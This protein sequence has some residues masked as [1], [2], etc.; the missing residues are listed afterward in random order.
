MTAGRPLPSGSSVTISRT[1]PKSSPRTAARDRRRQGRAGRARSRRGGQLAWVPPARTP[2]TAPGLDAR[3]EWPDRVVGTMGQRPEAGADE[4]RRREN[5][6]A[7]ERRHDV[8]FDDA[9]L[10]VLGQLDPVSEGEPIAY[11]T[12]LPSRS[13]RVS[14]SRRTSPRQAPARRRPSTASWYALGTIARNRTSGVNN[15]SSRSKSP[16]TMASTNEPAE[17]CGRRGRRAMADQSR[18][19]G[20]CEVEHGPGSCVRSDGTT[21][22]RPGHASHRRTT[23]FS[24]RCRPARGGSE[25]LTTR[26][27]PSDHGDSSAPACKAP[28]GADGPS[29]L[30]C[31]A[32]GPQ[33]RPSPSRCR[34][35]GP[36]LGAGW[37]AAE[38]WPRSCGRPVVRA[39]GRHRVHR[40]GRQRHDRRTGHCRLHPPRLPPPSTQKL[41]PLPPTGP[42]LLTLSLRNDPPQQTARLPSSGPPHPPPHLESRHTPPPPP[43]LHPPSAACTPPVR[44]P[45]PPLPPAPPPCPLSHSPS[46]PPPPSLPPPL[47]PYLLAPQRSAYSAKSSAVIGGLPSLTRC[48]RPRMASDR[49]MAR[50]TR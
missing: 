10:A 15:V 21:V 9:P 25:W 30:Q 47:P 35:A 26:P 34:R 46:S 42:S 41:P 7:I 8:L 45:R 19:G 33:P 13:A 3:I 20:R 2:C 4:S 49:S 28:T 6:V 44:G 31:R 27:M 17:A 14:P 37:G 38:R 36:R 39:Q 18:S 29:T 12:P 40:G 50:P 16:L 5:D 32:R 48:S 22:G 24:R 43:I 11:R 23:G 1:A